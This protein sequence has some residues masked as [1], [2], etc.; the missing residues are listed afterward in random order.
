MTGSFHCLLIKLFGC[1]GVIIKFGRKKLRVKKIIIIGILFICKAVYSEQNCLQRNSGYPY[2][3]GDAL[4][5][6][7]DWRLSVQEYFF[8]AEVQLG[9]TIFVEHDYLPIFEKDYLP[10]IKF[11]IVLLTPYCE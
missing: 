11:P 4:R 10:E 6:F 8:P 2:L 7:A 9:D 5:F 3:S 1:A